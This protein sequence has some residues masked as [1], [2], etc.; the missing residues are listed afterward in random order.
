MPGP[1]PRPPRPGLPPLWPGR[2][3]PATPGHVCPISARGLGVVIEGGGLLI[4]HLDAALQVKQGDGIGGGLH[5]AAI[6]RL[7]GA[8]RLLRLPPLLALGDLAQGPLHA[9]DK[10]GRVALHDVV[11][12]AGLQRRHGGLFADGARQQDER[13]VE[14]TL[15]DQSQRVQP[16]EVR[17]AIVAQDQVPRLRGQGRV[18]RGGGVHS[19]G[20]DGIAA[21]AQRLFGQQRII[22]D[23]VDDQHAQGRVS[24]AMLLTLS[25]G[26]A[27]KTSQ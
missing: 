1:R 24:I 2:R 19:L 13:Q 22:L 6:A 21:P 27:F 4:G 23:I 20:D 26:T 11:V 18:Q 8:Q 7:A 9:G 25:H 12:G 17:H 5:Q 10:A 3:A 16:A 14:A 15:A